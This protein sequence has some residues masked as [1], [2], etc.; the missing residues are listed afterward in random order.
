[1]LRAID[2]RAGKPY[3][4]T[5][6]QPTVQ[7]QRDQ[8]CARGLPSVAKEGIRD[9]RV[10]IVGYGPSLADTWERIA[11]LKFDAIWTVSKAHDFLVERE[12]VPT[13][14]TDSDYREH[15]AS[16]NSL[17]RPGVRYMMA[18]QIH[19]SYLDKLAGFDVRL[20]HVMN[21]GTFD[22]RYLKQPTQFDA[23]LQAARLAYE[24]GHREQEWFGMDA[25]MRGGVAH[26]GPHEGL[27]P[28]PCEIIIQ[29]RPVTMSTLLVRQAMHCEMMLRA[30]P[31]ML[32]KI[33][34]TGA[35]KPFLLERGKCRVW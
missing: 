9:A 18:T 7:A 20:F 26:A 25:S 22:H 15:K 28:E 34:G 21:I 33:H 6:V 14:H 2:L 10:A 3:Y 17:W 30:T 8:N 23:G 11:K 31:K 24:L 13:H 12:I 5:E 16:F 19:P 4:E 32:V 1:M 29:G 35:L 27:P